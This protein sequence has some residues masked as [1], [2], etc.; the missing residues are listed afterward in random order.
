MRIYMRDEFNCVQIS[1]LV[2]LAKTQRESCR[3]AEA[4]KRIYISFIYYLLMVGKRVSAKKDVVRPERVFL[5]EHSK[6]SLVYI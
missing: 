5:S 6:Q 2:L 1:H 3:P 4:Y